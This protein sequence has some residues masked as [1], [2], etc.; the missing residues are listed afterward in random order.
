[1][2][3]NFKNASETQM[4]VSIFFLIYKIVLKQQHVLHLLSGKNSF[5][6][7]TLHEFFGLQLEISPLFAIAV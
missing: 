3:F 5:H 4:N 6:T 2:A 1:M 7:H